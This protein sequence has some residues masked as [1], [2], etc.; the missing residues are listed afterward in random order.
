MLRFGGP[1][2]PDLPPLPLARLTRDGLESREA[3]QERA[4]RADELHDPRWFGSVFRLADR[5]RNFKQLPSAMP[6]ATP[7]PP[8]SA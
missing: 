6:S 2:N 7:P 5:P 3:Y 4:R 8:G 1:R